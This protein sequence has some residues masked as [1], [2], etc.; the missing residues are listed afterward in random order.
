MKKVLYLGLKTPPNSDSVQFTHFPV[1][2]IEPLPPP[3]IDLSPYTHIIFTSRTAVTLLWGLV[4]NKTARGK[5]II[6]VGAATARELSKNGFKAIVA[7]DETA[8]GVVK[9][10]SELPLQEAHLFWPHSTRARTVIPEALAARQV[11]FTE[12]CLYDVVYT[13]PDVIVDLD[14]YDEIFF[15][16]PSTVEGFLQIY[17]ELP[18]EKCRAI[19]PVTNAVL[20]N[21]GPGLA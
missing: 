16:S 21:W 1:I 14:Q 13:R 4:D 15:T 10:L 9:L 6:A 7:K 19:G 11:K 5:L 2:K 20:C 3:S 18:L 8:E 17:P 12:T